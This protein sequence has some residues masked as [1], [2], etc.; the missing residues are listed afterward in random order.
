MKLFVQMYFSPSDPNP[1]DIIK[2]VKDLGFEPVS[3]AYDFVYK[4]DDPSMYGKKV[5]ELT[6]ALKGTDTRFR[7]YSEK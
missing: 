6:E 1:L 7:L 5:K 4:Y 3:G 2:R